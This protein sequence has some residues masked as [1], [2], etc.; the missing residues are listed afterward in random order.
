MILPWEKK[1]FEKL[2]EILIDDSSIVFHFDTYGLVGQ[3][4]VS[5]LF[6]VTRKCSHMLAKYIRGKSM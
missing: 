3:A 1:I 5:K 4:K 2:L 6:S